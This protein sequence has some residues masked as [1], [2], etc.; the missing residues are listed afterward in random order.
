MKTERTLQTLAP[1]S[2]VHNDAEL[3]A[4]VGSQLVTTRCS[5]TVVNNES[6]DTFIIYLNLLAFLHY[7][8]K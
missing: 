1:S 3:A 2:G 6:T 8:I 7:M 4:I 5:E